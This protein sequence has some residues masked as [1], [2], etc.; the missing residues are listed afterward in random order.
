MTK[1]IDEMKEPTNAE[2]LRSLHDILRVDPQRYLR[3]VNGWI[4]QNPQNSHAYFDRHSAWMSIGEPQRALADLNKVIELRNHPGAMSFMARGEVYRH[5]GRHQEALEDFDRAETIDPADWQ[6][7]IVFGLLYQADSHA[8]LGN[9]AAAL[10]CCA[11]LPNDF[12]TPGINGA[13]SGNKA[14]VA[15]KLR[16]I[17]AAA[18]S[19][20]E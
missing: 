17:A 2:E 4:E 16:S 5:L 8:R 9:E 3:I 12:W 13:P 1:D 20:R 10:N 14:E 19:R 6:D 18:Q 7:G 11:R 15:E